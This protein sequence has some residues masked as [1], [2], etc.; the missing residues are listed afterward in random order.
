MQL[1]ASALEA[2]PP[3]PHSEVA[4]TGAQAQAA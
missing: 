4:C 1:G 3:K 2:T